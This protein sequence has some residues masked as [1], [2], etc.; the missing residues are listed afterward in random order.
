M[1]RSII[2][3]LLLV[4]L[5]VN[6]QIPCDDAYGAFCPEATGWGVGDCL[7]AKQ[8]EL[9]AECKQYIDVQE[10]C[11]EDINTH[12][13]GKEY[14]GDVFP[15]LTEWTKPDV[16]SPACLA[17]LPKKEEKKERKMSAEEKAK[18][19]KRRRTRNKAA[20]IAREF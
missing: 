8:S 16:L 9:S 5:V 2:I 6:G 12:C 11:K 13:T 3:S 19:D 17:A 4:L 7:L 15:C 18:A 1:L 20:K 10:K 14:T